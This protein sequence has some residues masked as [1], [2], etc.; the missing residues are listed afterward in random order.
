MKQ[1]LSQMHIYIDG[2][3]LKRVGNDCVEHS[4][5]FL[6]I[7]LD[8]NLTWKHHIIY[9]NKRISRALFAL[10]QVKFTLPL[11][12]LR[13]L[14]YALIHS[15]LSYGTIAWGTADK[16]YINSSMTLQKRAM[17]ILHNTPYNGH[18]DPLFKTSK[19]L[20][21][22]DVYEYQ[23]VLFMQ[24][25]MSGILPDSFEGIFT[26]NRDLPN[27]R[28]TRQSHLYHIPRCNK[29]FSRRLPLYSLPC[30]WNKHALHFPINPS[31]YQVKRIFKSKAMESYAD[32]VKCKNDRCMQCNQN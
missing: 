21:L 30:I 4:T 23:M 15:H 28:Q 6:G 10:K 1:D 32:T 11:D 25:Y 3:Q 18:T 7:H 29:R 26:L 13:T 16:Q 17:R 19:I 31:R 9:M 2:T 12:C 8:E 22:P 20:K 27:A 5:K 14:Y 24:D